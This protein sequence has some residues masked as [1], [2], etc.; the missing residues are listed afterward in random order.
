MTL[1]KQVSNLKL[2]KKLKELGVKQE[3]VFYYKKI[4]TSD[5]KP[6]VIYCDRVEAS[7]AESMTSYH[8]NFCSAFTVA[9]L[10]IRAKG[11]TYKILEDGIYRAELDMSFYSDRK[12]SPQ[13][14]AKETFDDKNEANCRAKLRIYLLKNKLINL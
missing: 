14:T 2:S 7:I 4:L 10:G 5:K 8:K 12:W 9:E 11:I 13:D 1:D 3:S 6:S